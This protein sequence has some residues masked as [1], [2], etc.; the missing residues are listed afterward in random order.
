MKKL[1]VCFL[2]TMFSLHLAKADQCALLPKNVADN[3]YHLLKNAGSYIDFC[4]PCMDKEPVTKHV[5]NLEI[6]SVYYKPTNKTLYQI[7]IDGT[8]IDIAYVYV[9][10]K[11]LG[12]QSE[13][14][15]IH[16]VPEY[17]DDYVLGRWHFEE[18]DIQ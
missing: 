9:N 7:L 13:C 2:V 12:I 16:D 3:A 6:Q 14:T 15:P 11:N 18:K 8:P 1:F 4:A 5:N 10:G 17:I